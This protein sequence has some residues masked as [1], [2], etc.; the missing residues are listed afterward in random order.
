S[1]NVSVTTSSGAVTIEAKVKAP[2]S[3]TISGTSANVN[4]VEFGISTQV[5]SQISGATNP[6]AIAVNGSFVIVTD[7]N[8]SGGGANRVLLYDLNGVLKAT[9]AVGDTPD[10]V[11]INP[12]GTVAYVTCRRADTIYVIDLTTAAPTLKGSFSLPA[13]NND[14]FGVG[15]NPVLS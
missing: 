14:W 12:A 13:G 1:H 2:N 8:I 11:A 4:D 9:I 7:A 5:D 10:G 15:F 3:V 6:A